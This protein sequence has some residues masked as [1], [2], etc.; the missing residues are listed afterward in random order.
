MDRVVRGAGTMQLKQNFK[1]TQTGWV[2]EGI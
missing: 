1:R 2:P